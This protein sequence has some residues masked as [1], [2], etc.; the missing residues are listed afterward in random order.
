MDQLHKSS[1]LLSYCIILLLLLLE[2]NYHSH[3]ELKDLN[4]PQVNTSA[5]HVFKSFFKKYPTLKLYFVLARIFSHFANIPLNLTC[6]SRE[7]KFNILP[8]V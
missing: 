6:G 5:D 2:M 1:I 4:K 8:K 7:V 3:L